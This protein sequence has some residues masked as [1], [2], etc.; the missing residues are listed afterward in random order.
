[1]LSVIV[2]RG[3]PSGLTGLLAGLTAAAVEGLVRDVQLVGGDDPGLLDALCEATGARIAPD[4][5]AA[6]A[7]ARSDWLLVVPPELRLGDGWVERLAD[8][9]AKGGGEAR[10]QGPGAGILRPGPR[11]VL[12]GRA[13]AERAAAGG[14]R[15]L[16]RE[17]GRGVRRLG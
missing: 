13:K 16:A 2:T 17:L 10:L 5:P 11:G 3:A 4:L 8:H 14:L 12:I 7:H 1:M 15:R 9:L 6:V